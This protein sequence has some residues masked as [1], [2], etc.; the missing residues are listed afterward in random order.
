ML[1][2]LETPLKAMKCLQQGLSLALGMRW[3]GMVAVVLYSVDTLVVDLTRT[4]H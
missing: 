2:V 1:E 3:G 4:Q